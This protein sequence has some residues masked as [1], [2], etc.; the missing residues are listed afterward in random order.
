MNTSILKYQKYRAIV[1]ETINEVQ[2][3]HTNDIIRN[4]GTFLATIK[5]ESISYSKDKSKV[6]HKLKD[7]LTRLMLKIEENPENLEE[8]DIYNHYNY[9][10]QKLKNIEEIE[11]EGYKRRIKN[12]PSY[13]Q[14]EPNI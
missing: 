12:L 3:L 1:I 8:Q 11:I 9:L 10:K 4:W 14:A 7:K 5:T 13:E 6:K 2:E